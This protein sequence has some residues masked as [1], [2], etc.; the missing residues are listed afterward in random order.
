MNTLSPEQISDFQKNGYFVK[1]NL[2]DVEEVHILCAA[3]NADS[4]FKQHAHDL[5]ADKA[6]FWRPVKNGDTTTGKK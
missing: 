5:F 3:A 2:F 4:S 6:A 1:T